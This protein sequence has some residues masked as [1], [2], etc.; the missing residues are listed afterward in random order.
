MGRP[1]PSALLLLTNVLLSLL[2]AAPQSHLPPARL[3]LLTNFECRANVHG[4]LLLSKPRCQQKLQE[5]PSRPLPILALSTVQLCHECQTCVRV[6]LALNGTG[7]EGLELHF[8]VLR[9]NRS[10][11]LQILKRRKHQT[12][13]GMLVQFD[14]FPAESGQRV[15]VSLETIPSGV[16]SLSQSF[17]ITNNQLGPEF[18]HKWLP[19]ARAIEVS[20]P[21]GPAIS[22]RLCHQLALECEE[23]RQPFHQQALVSSHQPAVLLYEL[24]LPCLC[25]EASYEHH[26]GVRKNVCPFQDQPEAYGTDLWSSVQFRDYSTSD[27]AEMAM[28]LSGRCLLSLTA[29]LCW[30]ESATPEATCQDIPNST[31]TGLDQEYILEDVDVHPQLCFK[32]S[33]RNSSHIE[34]PHRTDT[35]WKVSVSVKFLQLHL[36]FHSRVPASF[37]SAF[38]QKQSPGQCELEPP[39]YTITHREGPGLGDLDLILPW[40]ALRSCVLVWRSDVRFAGKQLLCPDVTHRHWGLLAFGVS[41]G[42]GLLLV[43]VLLLIR[44]GLRRLHRDVPSKHNS[45]PILLIYS[46]DSEEHKQLVCAFA[47]LLRS[48][49]CCPVLLDLWELGHVGRLGILPWM[50]ARREHVSREQGQVLLLWSVGS[51]RAYGLWQGKKSRD[52]GKVPEPHDLFGAAMACLQGELQG[53]P[54]TVQQSD[55][56]IAYF[57]KLCGRRDIPH[58]LRFLPRYRLPQELPG[59]VRVL[60]GPSSSAPSWLHASAKALV[61]HLLKAEKKK[62]PRSRVCQPWRTTTERL[63]RSLAPLAHPKLHRPNCT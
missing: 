44:C 63:A 28:S 1:T 21:E 42:L 13:T 38:C 48:A 56:V 10:G 26:D 7:I 55:W 2:S 8:L 39:L 52:G 51:A 34:C 32:F 11:W 23:L 30:K 20:V 19:E 41:L 27:K 53:M 4:P 62:G 15:L 17:F 6:H 3:R 61:C 33:Y 12:D 46:P 49:L 22:V 50:Y 40:Q 29:S 35:A 16:L 18:C 5:G 45:R 58:A 43:T 14:C 47:A 31:I 36:H 59:L 9:S 57:S 60:Q 24:L 25:I 37:S 54:G